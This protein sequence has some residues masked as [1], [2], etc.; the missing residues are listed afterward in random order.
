[1]QLSGGQR[2][3]LSIARAIYRKPKILLFDEATSSLD[4]N[5]EK[6]LV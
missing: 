3:R 1:M 6:V 2:Q 5:S 4:T